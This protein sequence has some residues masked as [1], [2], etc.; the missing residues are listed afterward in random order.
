MLER[1]RE[2]TRKHIKCVDH[3]VICFKLT[4]TYSQRN[5][6]QW[7]LINSNPYFNNR[8][9]HATSILDQLNNEKYQQKVRWWWS[10]MP[11][12]TPSRSIGHRWSAST[13]LCLSPSVQSDSRCNLS[14]GWT[15]QCLFSRCFVVFVSAYFPQGSSPMLAGLC[16]CLIS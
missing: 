12:I 13:L 15:F 8:S 3:G 10:L 4:H 7:R 2:D 16:R 9:R 1:R 5:K 6:L 11:F 14:T